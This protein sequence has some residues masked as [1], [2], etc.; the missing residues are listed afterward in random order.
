MEIIL[1]ER[2]KNLGL[3]GDVIT[4]KPG[5]A[6]NYLLPQKKA[7]RATKVNLEEFKNR[8]AQLEANNLKLKKE[9]EAVAA[10]ME[11]LSLVVIRNAGESGQLYGSVTAKDLGV[12]LAEQG[13]TAHH[14]QISIDKPIKMVGLHKVFLTLHPEVEVALQ[15]NVAMTEEEAEAQAKGV[16]VIAEKKKAQQQEAS[17]FASQV[18]TAAEDEEGD[19]IPV[20]DEKGKQS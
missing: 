18:G 7:L 10:K 20:E 17:E 3:M 9:A 14:K 15:V 4:V 5:Y 8:K 11:G 12:S 13:I 1:L 2:V 19:L 6:R 16:D